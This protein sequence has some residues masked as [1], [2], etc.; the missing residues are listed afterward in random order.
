MLGLNEQETKRLIECQREYN[1]RKSAIMEIVEAM[2]GSDEP[3]ILTLYDTVTVLEKKNKNWR[4]EEICQMIFA[5][6]ASTFNEN[7]FQEV[8]KEKCA[9]LM[10][11]CLEYREHET[12]RGKRLHHLFALAAMQYVLPQI[13]ELCQWASFGTS[14]VKDAYFIQEQE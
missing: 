5:W 1:K 2:N 12:M 9:E 10:D 3:T 7:H 11:L 14:P 4:N 8:C 6:Q 13:D